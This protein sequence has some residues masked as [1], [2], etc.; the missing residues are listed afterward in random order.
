M[1]MSNHEVSIGELPIEW[2][3]PQHDARQARDEELKK[4]GD[5]EQHRY[6]KA[7]LSAPHGAKPVEN[8]YSGGN[9]DQHRGGR[10]ERVARGRHPDREHVMSPY[11]HAD[12]CDRARCRDHHRVTENHLAREYRDD[13]GGER[14][15][16]DDQDVNFRMTEDPK[17]VLP[18][19]GGAPGLGIEEVCAEEAVE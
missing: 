18:Q 12:E 2:C 5:A 11:T 13:L 1:E 3:N 14:E 4:E 7:Q 10:E 8:L 16:R 19:D 15:C 9:P 6:F 17:E